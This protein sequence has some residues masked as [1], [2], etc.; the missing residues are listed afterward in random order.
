MA[1]LHR[2][3]Q[4]RHL[5]NCVLMDGSGDGKYRQPGGN[6]HHHG[7][8]QAACGLPDVDQPC[9]KHPTDGIHGAGQ[10]R[11]AEFWP[12]QSPNGNEWSWQECAAQCARHADCA[13]WSG[14]PAQ[15]CHR[16]PT[17]APISKSAVVAW[18]TLS[19]SATLAWRTFG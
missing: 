7:Y 3:V 15:R 6:V 4:L 17:P 18:S 10:H 16:V 5:K 11:V 2:Y 12:E 13:Y 1:V 19:S 9:T 8:R 14:H